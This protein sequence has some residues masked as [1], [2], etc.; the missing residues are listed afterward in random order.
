MERRHCPSLVAKNSAYKSPFPPTTCD[1]TNHG[2]LVEVAFGSML[3]K[4]ANPT[5]H[6]ELTKVA[7]W[8]SD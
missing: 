2:T 5:H 6:R 4:K 7:G 8:K 3:L 1:S